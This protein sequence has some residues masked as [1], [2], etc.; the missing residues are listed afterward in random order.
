MVSLSLSDDYIQIAKRSNPNN[1]MLEEF[2]LY[3]TN[4]DDEGGHNGNDDDNNDNDEEDGNEGKGQPVPEFNSFSVDE[5]PGEQWIML[6]KNFGEN[7]KIKVEVT[8]FDG[9]VPIKK[10]WKIS[11][12]YPL[13]FLAPGNWMMSCKIRSEFLEARGVNDALAVFLHGCMKHQDKTEF[14]QWMGTVKSFI[15][16]K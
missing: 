5:R 14:I 11:S 8:M 2:N 16:K 1:S 15:E 6:N 3:L 10:N 9:S 12:T 13:F 7:E 4:E